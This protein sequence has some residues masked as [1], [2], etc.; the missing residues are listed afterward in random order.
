MAQVSTNEDRRFVGDLLANKEVFLK[1]G[2]KIEDDPLRL[3]SLWLT[4]TSGMV[5]KIEAGID[6]RLLPAILTLKLKLS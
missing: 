4:T 2:P 1:N 5:L 6:T 3:L